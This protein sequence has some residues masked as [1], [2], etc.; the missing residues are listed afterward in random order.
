MDKITD[1]RKSAADN[2]ETHNVIDLFQVMPDI[3]ERL[4]GNPSII[5]IGT[6]HGLL[7]QAFR[8]AGLTNTI[9]FDTDPRFEKEFPGIVRTAYATELPL[10]GGSVDIAISSRLFSDPNF[11]NGK[12]TRL[13][14][15]IP[16]DSSVARLCNRVFA[17]VGRVLKLGGIFVIAND[18]CIPVTEE[19][20]ELLK[21]I[22]ISKTFLGE[23][24]QKTNATLLA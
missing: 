8:R 2:D 24:L 22:Y 20:R 10:E 21:I 4:A 11:C 23:I 16:P 3:E 14:G 1:L 17:E 9:G 12:G 18:F 13:N 19:N 5:D 6:A 15:M 7:V